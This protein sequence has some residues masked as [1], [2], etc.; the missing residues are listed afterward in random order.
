VPPEK[1]SEFV[2]CHH[3]PLNERGDT[4]ASLA[5]SG[6]PANMQEKLQNWLHTAIEQLGGTQKIAV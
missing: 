2:P 1:R 3:I 6:D 5:E 4:I